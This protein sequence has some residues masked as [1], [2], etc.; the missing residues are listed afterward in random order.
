MFSALSVLFAVRW[1]S[2]LANRSLAPLE[3]GG[4]LDEAGQRRVLRGP[5]AQV[6]VSVTVWSAAAVFFGVLAVVLFEAG[7]RRYTSGAVWTR[8]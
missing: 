5:L 2:A 6:L 7:L 3:P 8:A 4:K 1:G